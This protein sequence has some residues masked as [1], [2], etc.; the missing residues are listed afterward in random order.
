MHLAGIESAPCLVRE[1]TFLHGRCGTDANFCGFSLLCGLF[2]AVCHALSHV[3][4]RQDDN[5]DD[6]DACQGTQFARRRR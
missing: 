3:Q 5:N 2:I 6:Y 1:E 4:R